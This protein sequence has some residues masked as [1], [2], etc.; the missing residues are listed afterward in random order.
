MSTVNIHVP[1]YTGSQA[2][3][4]NTS[5]AGTSNIRPLEYNIHIH[6]GYRVLQSEPGHLH[7]HT[8]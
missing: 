3:L 7:M 2:T 6:S 5:S 8:M 4:H 1:L